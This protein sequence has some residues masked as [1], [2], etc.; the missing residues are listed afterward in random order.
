MEV[1]VD[2]GP[3]AVDALEATDL[4]AD[5]WSVP[6]YLQKCAPW[7]H[8][9]DVRALQRED[10]QAWTVSDLPFL[11]AARLR[12][13]DSA[14]SLRSRRHDARV[15]AEREH[16]DRVVDD[17]IAGDDSEMLVMSMLRGE[18]TQSILVDE[19]ALPSADPAI[20]P[21]QSAP[22]ETRAPR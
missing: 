9:D 11:D 6:A 12:L 7:L 2:V 15:A 20:A 17:M 1:A 22:R 18:D 3:P 19:T 16:M 5:L 4:V 14:A 13:G 8:P 21:T 10:P